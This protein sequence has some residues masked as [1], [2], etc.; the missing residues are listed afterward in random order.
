MAGLRVTRNGAPLVSTF[1]P[2]CIAQIENN[3]QNIDIDKSFFF[4]IARGVAGDLAVFALN[5]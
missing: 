1:L 5:H 3:S 2:L 4:L